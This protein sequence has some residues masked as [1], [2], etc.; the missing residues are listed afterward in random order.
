MPSPFQALH[1]RGLIL[2]APTWCFSIQ[3]VAFGMIDVGRAWLVVIYILERSKYRT[4]YLVQILV[5]MSWNDI[6]DT[7]IGC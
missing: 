4:L 3:K 1:S 5:F 6:N 2:G 7:N